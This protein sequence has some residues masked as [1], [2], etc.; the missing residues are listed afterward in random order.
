MPDTCD[1]AF[2]R[3]AKFLFGLVCGILNRGKIILPRGQI[4][5]TTEIGGNESFHIYNAMGGC[6]FQNGHRQTTKILGRGQRRA[7]SFIDRQEVIEITE[8]ITAI[9]VENATDINI[10]L[11]GQT[12]DER[13]RCAAFQMRVQFDLWDILEIHRKLF[14]SPA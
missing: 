9:S 6:L 7:G 14:P 2:Q 11:S 3:D 5:T 12:T 4:A 13:W 1:D 8:C 10:L